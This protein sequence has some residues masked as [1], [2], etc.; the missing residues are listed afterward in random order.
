MI[1][2]RNAKLVDNVSSSSYLACLILQKRRKGEKDED[3]CES[4]FSNF[5]DYD[6]LK[7]IKLD[8][9]C[10]ADFFKRF[11]HSGDLPLTSAETVDFDGDYLLPSFIDFHCHSEF[12]YL[13]D[14]TIT[15][16]RD[17]LI[18]GEVVGN[19]GISI[20]P[21]SNDGVQRKLLRDNV[22]SILGCWPEGL[23]EWRGFGQF[24]RVFDGLPVANHIKFLQ[25]HSALRIA[26]MGG[27]ANRKAEKS[28]I[29]K[30]Q[31]MLDEAMGSGALGFSTGLYYAPCVFADESEILALLEVVREHDG[32]FAIHRREEGNGGL[33]STAEAISYAKKAKVRLQI[34]HLKAIGDSNQN[35]VDAILDMIDKAHAEGLDV[36]FDQYPYVYGSTSLAS[37]LPPQILSDGESV[38][39]FRLMNDASYREKTKSLM[40]NPLGFESIAQLVRHDR[41][42]IQYS[43]SF[44]DMIGKSIAEIASLWNKDSLDAILDIIARENGI[45]TM[46]DLTQSEE[47][48]LKIM[49]HP[50]SIYCTDALFAGKIWHD[51]SRNASR[52]MLRSYSKQVGIENL[53]RR[54]TS[55]SAERLRLE[56]KKK[57]I[58][59]A[60]VELVR[61]KL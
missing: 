32:L 33:A 57:I 48:L 29:I 13:R 39:K 20:Y 54:A 11:Q 24:K 22:L 1:C 28:E 25:G 41:I 17:D 38:Y 30:M 55:R 23:P 47:N 45:C 31:R 50:L 51:R 21:V 37:L 16:R 49:S 14:P 10:D 52:H 36:A 9:P 2:I 43:D 44:G 4:G 3:S 35:Q 19:C 15:I 56:D 60:V 6:V 53:V 5:S 26:A 12:L 8:E 27:N 61:F 58:E 18:G 40:M 34:S 7:I 59:G 46:R 42:F